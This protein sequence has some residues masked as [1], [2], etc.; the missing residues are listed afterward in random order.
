MENSILRLPETEPFRFCFSNNTTAAGTASLH[1]DLAGHF[2]IVFR[3]FRFQGD[4]AGCLGL[5]FE[6]VPYFRYIRTIS[7]TSSA[8]SSDD[9]LLRGMWLRM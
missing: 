2:C 3:V 8:A 7:T 5:E 1:H 6:I 9:L 4:L